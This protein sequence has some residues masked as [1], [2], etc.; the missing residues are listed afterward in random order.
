MKTS[1]VFLPDPITM[2]SIKYD[3]LGRVKEIE[4]RPLEEIKKNYPEYFKK[5]KQPIAIQVRS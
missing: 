1:I 3:W 5:Q 4:F 2:K